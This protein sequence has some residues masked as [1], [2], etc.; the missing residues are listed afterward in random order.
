MH[1]VDRYLL[2]Q[3]VK[4]FVICWFSLTGLYVVVDAFSNLDE[5][6]AY[7]A[8]SNRKLLPVMGEFYLFRSIL[9]FDRLSAILAMIA[10]IFTITWIQRHNEL[11]ALMAAGISRVRTA[12]PVLA[13][14]VVVTIL[15][16][17]CR[18]IL[19]PTFRNQM[20]LDPRELL[21]DTFNELRNY[22]DNETNVM[23]D[24]DFYSPKEHLIHR[25][26]F[27]LPSGLD[28]YGIHLSAKTAKYLPPADGR[29][30]G[31]LFQSVTAPLA[32]LKQPSL[33]QRDREVILTPV[34]HGDWIQPDQVF[35]VSNVDFEQLTAGK[36]MRQLMSTKE[37]IGGLRNPS[38]DYGA[39]VRVTIHSRIA[40]P[41]L[42]VTLLFLGLPLVMRRETKNIY[43]AVGMCVLLT[44]AFMLVIIICQH[45]GS[46]LYLR[47][48]LAAWLPLMIFVPTAVSLYDRIDT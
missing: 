47:P 20:S 19:I 1:I 11:T 37:L 23:L 42:D 3:Y 13:A 29:P 25:P 40:Q 15:A 38:L 36:K 41:L 21:D 39:D 28:A 7:A 2:R 32:L 22:V 17:C 4:T 6:L 26:K 9:F 10:T 43:A 12:K 24:G 31:Y 33:K 8:Q 34:D 5:F 14:A 45:L 46:V 48:T 27:V 16:V 18:E 30:G 35:F 44:A